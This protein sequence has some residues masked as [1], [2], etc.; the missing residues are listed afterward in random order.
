MGICLTDHSALVSWRSD[1]DAIGVSVNQPNLYFDVKEACLKKRAFLF[2]SDDGFC[3]LKP[4]VDGVLVWV[5][6]SVHPVDWKY[7]LAIFDQLACLVN[8]PSLYFI[9]TRKGFFRVAPQFGFSPSPSVW[10]DKPVTLWKK[11]YE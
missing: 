8:A 2:S 1:I 6:R 9:T 4:N 11:Y 10:M 5:A 7:Y 3:I